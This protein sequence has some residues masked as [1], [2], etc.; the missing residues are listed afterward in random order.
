MYSNWCIAKHN[1]NPYGLS[2]KV[3]LSLYNS[4]YTSNPVWAINSGA[5]PK[6][7]VVTHSSYWQFKETHSASN[8]NVPKTSDKGDL[9]KEDTSTSKNSATTK[10]EVKTPGLKIMAIKIFQG[11]YKSLEPYTYVRGRGRGKYVCESCGIRCKKPS[12]LKKHIRSHTDLRPYSCNHCK[13]SFK[14]KGNLTKHMKSKAHQKKCIEMGIVP[15]PVYIDE[16]QIDM[17]ALEAQCSLSKNAKIVAR[18]D[19][20][21]SESVKEEEELEEEG[22]GPEEEEEGLE[23]E[24]VGPEEEEELDDNEAEIMEV[25]DKIREPERAHKEEEPR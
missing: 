13:F 14:T 19:K 12:M 6:S 3:L 22:E 15:V 8:V 9:K 24:D 16:S 17:S 4:H 21:R 11:G 5:N 1:P 2:A 25:D 23:E 20:S 10:A 18:G 7:G